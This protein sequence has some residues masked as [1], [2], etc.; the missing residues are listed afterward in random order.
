MAAVVESIGQVESFG[1]VAGLPANDDEFAPRTRDL[2]TLDIRVLLAT[3][4]VFFLFVTLLIRIVFPEGQR[5]TDMVS[6]EQSAL[7]EADEIGR[8]DIAGR[9][10]GNIGS[11]IAHLGDVRRDVKIRPADSIAWSDAS[12]GTTVRNR[13]AVQTFYNSRARVDFKENNEL[14]IGQNSL[15][16][17]RSGAA[18]PFLER[19]DPAVVVMNGELTGTVNAKYGALGVQFPAGLVE[20]AATSGSGEDV[21]FRVGINPDGSS[22]IAIYSGQADVNIAG[23]HYR[24]SANQGLT[25]AEDGRTSGARMLPSLPSIRVPYDNAVAKFLA[26]PPRVRFLWGELPDARIY[27]LEIA[28]DP[29]FEEILVDEYLDEPTFTHGNLPSGDYYWRIS[30]RDGWVQGPATTPRRLSV[31]RDSTPPS[32]ELKPVQEVTAGHYALRG[33]TTPDTRVFVLGQ[34]VETS[35]SG[36]FEFLFTPQPGTQSIVVESIDVVGNVAYSSQILH[37]PGPPGRSE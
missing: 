13:D 12:E 20:L 15:V 36:S 19:R 3:L 25:I 23:D 33:R 10:V 9:S 2:Q 18:D 6:G 37:V 27:R 17:F 11:F 22:T 34:Q 21:D 30:A 26:A 35:S 31:V 1:Q 28:A 24:I 8:V 32:L 14:R 29:G 5:L 16:V 4:I 7:L